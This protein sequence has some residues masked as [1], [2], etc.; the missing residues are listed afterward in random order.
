MPTQRNTAKIS[1]KNFIKKM[2]FFRK[3]Y[4]LTQVELGSMYGLTQSSYSAFERGNRII[5]IDEMNAMAKV[6]G[7]DAIQLLHPSTQPP[8]IEDLPA[9]TRKLIQQS[10][11]RGKAPRNAELNFPQ[12][13]FNIIINIAANKEFT[14]STIY[15]LLPKDK[16]AQ[17]IP[18]RVSDVLSNK[19]IQSLV[20]F[21]GKK[22]ASKE[23]IY[24]KKETII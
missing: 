23:K 6:F 2:I 21:T 9:K 16:Q 18:Q 4:N 1:K 7:M 17:V 8:F 15:K 5:E 13:V 3:Y 24:R 11:Q 14:R 20:E 22:T 12:T 19:K 10:Q